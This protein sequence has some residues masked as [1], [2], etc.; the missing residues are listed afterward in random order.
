[1]SG[2]RPRL[3][4]S[5]ACGAGW[6]SS[7]SRA[8]AGSAPGAP[9][10]ARGSGRRAA[11]WPGLA[12]RS[13]RGVAAGHDLDARS[14]RGRA[15]R[16]AGSTACAARSAPAPSRR[17]PDA[18]SAR[19]PTAHRPC[20]PV[21]EA[22]IRPSARRLATNSS[23]MSMRS[24]TMLGGGAAADHHVVHRQAV[25]DALRRRARR[26]LRASRGA[27]PRSRRRACGASASR[28]W[29]SGMSVMKPS[30][31]WLM[32]T[33]GRSWRASWR[34][35]PSMVPSP[36]TTT[37]RSHAAPSSVGVERAV[38]G[39]AGVDAAVWRSNETSQAL[40][41]QELAISSS[42]RPDALGLVL[43]DERGVTE[44]GVG[45]RRITPQRLP[46]Q[47]ALAARSVQ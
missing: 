43:A 7:S 34:A 25:E 27:L 18:G 21:G 10:G 32:P 47:G 24:S 4:A 22:T 3:R 5:A 31:P 11:G 15:A 35:M 9:S 29:P 33:S 2:V 1:M 16:S 28:S 13:W 37:A 38:V 17:C 36:P 14:R 23:P 20:E 12:C 42:T 41:H 44:A 8:G 45:M 30:R 26:R 46:R 6:R 19:R 39:D 40:P